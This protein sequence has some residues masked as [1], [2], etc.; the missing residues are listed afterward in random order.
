MK[1]KCISHI[2]T[3]NL[4]I[5]LDIIMSYGALKFILIMKAMKCETMKMS[6]MMN[7]DNDDDNNGS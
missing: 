6:M 4:Q 5:I 1:I 2:P 7:D 3:W